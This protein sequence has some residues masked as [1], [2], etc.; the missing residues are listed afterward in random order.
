MES[1]LGSAGHCKNQSHFYLT[2][3]IAFSI[4]TVRDTDLMSSSPHHDSSHSTKPTIFLYPSTLTSVN[5]QN[6]SVHAGGFPCT[7]CYCTICYWSVN[8]RPDLP[9]RPLVI[10]SQSCSPSDRPPVNF[11]L[12]VF[13]ENKAL[14]CTLVTKAVTVIPWSLIPLDKGRNCTTVLCA[15]VIF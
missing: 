12:C 7:I 13:S 8:Q 4:Y 1:S 9:D 3:C 10:S 11:P 6:S 14:N 2:A 5:K 15:S